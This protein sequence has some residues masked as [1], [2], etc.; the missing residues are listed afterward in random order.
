MQNYA[1][2]ENLYTECILSTV[3]LKQQY[4]YSSTW[5]CYTIQYQQWWNIYKFSGRVMRLST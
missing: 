2:S 1:L 3:I 5:Y 4:W